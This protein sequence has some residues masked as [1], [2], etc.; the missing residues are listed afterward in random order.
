M[1]YAEP[2]AMMSRVHYTPVDIPPDVKRLNDDYKFYYPENQEIQFK[3]KIPKGDHSNTAAIAIKGIRESLN[4]TENEFQILQSFRDDNGFD[5]FYGARKLHNTTVV[6]HQFQLMVKDGEVVSFESAANGKFVEP[7]TAVSDQFTLEQAVYIAREQFGAG[8]DELPARKVYVEKSDGTLALAH[9]FQIRDRRNHA[10]YEVLKVPKLSPDEGFDI[11]KDPQY[12]PSSPN[13][14]H[15]D[16]TKSFTDTQGNNVI[17]TK[18]SQKPD[19]G[20]DLNFV[21]QYDPTKPPNDTFNAAASAKTGNFQADNFGKGGA[22]GDRVTIE[23]LSTS[24]TNNANFA[25]PPDGQSGHMNMFRF[26]AFSPNRDSG[27]ANDVVMH[28]YCHGVSNRLTGGS[29]QANCLSGTESSGMGEGWSDT[30]ALYLNRKATETRDIQVKI[31][32]YLT[33][34]GKGFRKFPYS[35][36][37]TVNPNTYEKLNGLTVVHDI[38]EIWAIMLYEMYWNLVDKYGFSDNW[39][40]SNQLK[41]NIIAL[42]LVMGGMTLQPCNPKLLSARDAII[43]FDLHYYQGVNKCLIWKAFSKRGMGPN[44]SSVGGKYTNDFSLPAGC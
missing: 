4:M 16:G 17:V 29:R 6:S 1:N 3:L 32:A 27:F 24:G 21:T 23:V 22:G 12:V 7:E 10:T 14:W 20:A 35:T 41:G 43:R 40:D 19:G 30:C 15:S 2:F 25:T 11:L 31:A 26:D 37:M 5:H 8:I 18:A 42:R 36:D 33:K 9:Q 28:E 38:G 39:Y 44:A 34:N 13:G